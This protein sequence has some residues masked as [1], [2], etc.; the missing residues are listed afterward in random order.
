[1]DEPLF[2]HEDVPDAAANFL[3]EFCDIFL[4]EPDMVV[5]AMYRANEEINKL[6]RQIAE[7]NEFSLVVDKFQDEI[8]SLVINELK[9]ENYKLRLA[10]LRFTRDIGAGDN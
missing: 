5:L 6:R 10:L 8:N 3:A 9:A 2:R 1:M 4:P 7:E